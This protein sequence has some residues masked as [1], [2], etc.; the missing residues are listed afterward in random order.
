MSM[1]IG[2]DPASD[3]GDAVIV[4]YPRDDI[5]LVTL[6]RPAKLNAMNQP[7]VDGIYAACDEIDARP[8]LRVAIL[9]G[10]GRGFC[11]GADLGGFGTVPGT[12]DAGQIFQ[13]FA[14]QQ[15]ITGLIPRLQH[16]K[17]PV[18]AAITGFRIDIR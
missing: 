3:D 12:E 5:A 2:R 10:E 6:N 9:T 7:L 17:V 18:I 1:P 13:F 16:L 15:K 4:T 11:A 8:R 14:I